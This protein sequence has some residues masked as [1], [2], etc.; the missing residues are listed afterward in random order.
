[1]ATRKNG[2]KQ[3][4]IVRTYSAG[5]WF[6]ALGA[7]KGKEVALTEARRIWR[8]FGANTCSELALH[9]LD[10]SRSKVAEP[11]SVDLTEAIEVI[12]AAPAA[13]ASIKGAKWAQ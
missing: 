8:W 9:G 2:K 7:R 4:V 12:A 6:G 13:V 10:Q 11:V 5:V 3:Y 1:M